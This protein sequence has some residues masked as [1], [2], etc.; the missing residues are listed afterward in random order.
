MVF[1]LQRQLNSY[2]ARLDH[3]NWDHVTGSGR[4]HLLVCVSIFC[5]PLITVTGKPISAACFLK[6]NDS[7]GTFTTLKHYCICSKV[8]SKLT[9]YPKNSSDDEWFLI[10]GY[11]EDAGKKSILTALVHAEYVCDSKLYIGPF[12]LF[13]HKKH[14][15]NHSLSAGE[16]ILP[17][18]VAF[19]MI[20]PAGKSCKVQLAGL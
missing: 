2:D 8:I 4:G 9:R 3:T 13:R 5:P 7:C 6:I 19:Q 18:H 11:V 16:A 12:H 15:G 10:S 1:D 14:T 20:S 17:P